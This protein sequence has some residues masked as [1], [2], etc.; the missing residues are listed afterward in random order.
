MAASPIESE[1]ESQQKRA[2]TWER[3]RVTDVL[4]V[5]VL[6]HVEKS[7]KESP[8]ADCVSS[9]W[10]G[11]NTVSFSVSVSVSVSDSV[12]D[13]EVSSMPRSSPVIRRFF[14]MF[15]RRICWMDN[16]L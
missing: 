3:F 4:D 2:V 7:A 12:S 1:L 6:S 10:F 11:F 15:W 9:V 5:L 13:F 14:A 16:R 8:S